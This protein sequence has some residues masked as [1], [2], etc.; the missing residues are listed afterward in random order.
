MTRR[1]NH[2]HQK[3]HQCSYEHVS[4]VLKCYFEIMWNYP[5]RNRRYT[6]LSALCS[7]KNENLD[8]PWSIFQS[9][10]DSVLLVS[11]TWWAPS[12][13]PCR[14]GTC[15]VWGWAWW[16]RPGSAA[17]PAAPGRDPARRSGVGTR[18]KQTTT[19]HYGLAVNAFAQSTILRPRFNLRH[20]R[21]YLVQC[22]LHTLKYE[23]SYM[24]CPM[25]ERS[26]TN[27]SKTL[28]L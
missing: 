21:S 10:H 1:S 4:V 26:G 15:G 8:L 20:R 23:Q 6:E 17:R 2:S 25:A 9:S 28:T 3:L 27:Q 5:L 14:A 19:C 22:F 13:S 7:E 12:C 16:P 24:F 18:N 11:L